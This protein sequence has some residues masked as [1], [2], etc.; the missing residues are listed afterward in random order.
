MS[1]F[2]KLAAVFATTLIASSA[3]T[4]TGIGNSQGNIL[5][6]TRDFLNATYPELFGRRLLLRL[7]TSQGIDKSWR[8]I[9]EIRF[10]VEPFDP[11]SERMLNP[12]FDAKTGKQLGPPRNRVFEGSIW[13]NPEGHLHQFSTCEC[14][15]VHYKENQAIR[16][17]VGSRPE[18]SEA[19]AF[20]ALKE[21]GARYSP[22][23]KDEFVKAIRLEN[24][25]PFLGHFTVR[26]IEF[27][28]LAEPHEGSFASLWWSVKLDIGLSTNTHSTYTLIF[29]PFD[30]KLTQVIHG[31]PGTINSR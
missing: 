27:V 1:K 26:S 23:N 15:V 20:V 4:Q 21:A 18:W 29:E 31:L 9:N 13:F 2:H 14:D 11:L 3:F 6:Q 19:Q 25:E 24:Y 5:A 10:L 12:P 17:L 16:K 28:G 7:D 30:G 22:E 8:I